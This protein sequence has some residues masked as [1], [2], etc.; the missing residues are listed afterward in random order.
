MHDQKQSPPVIGNLAAEA[1]GLGREIARAARRLDL[2]RTAHEPAIV[3]RYLAQSGERRPFGPDLEVG[4]DAVAQVLGRELEGE[5][6]GQA[7]HSVL[8]GQDGD[9]PRYEAAEVMTYTERGEE[10]L[11]LQ[12]AYERFRFL[13]EEV[14][15]HLS[16]Q[17]VLLEM[18]RV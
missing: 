2:G 9:G 18:S 5:Y 4:L 17:H 6:L 13:R 14:L 10:L 7:W 12:R 11:Q 15:D 8:A 3:A 1:V 16:A